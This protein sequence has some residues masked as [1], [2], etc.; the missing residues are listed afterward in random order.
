[1]VPVDQPFDVNDASIDFLSSQLFD[2]QNNHLNLNIL[3]KI[4]KIDLIDVC[5]IFVLMNLNVLQV[6]SYHQI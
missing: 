6:V 3:Q 4:H 2:S 1:M 5:Y